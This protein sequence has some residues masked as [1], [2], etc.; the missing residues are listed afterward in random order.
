MLKR[1][2]QPP[3]AKQFRS[4][5]IRGYYM[6]KLEHLERL[7]QGVASWN[8]WRKDNPEITPDLSK[9]KLKNAD[10]R[11]V[12]LSSANLNTLD[13][14]RAD[15]IA[16]EDDFYSD[17]ENLDEVMIDDSELENIYPENQIFGITDL[18]GADLSGAD[19]SRATF[20][21]ARLIG[22]KLNNSFLN[23]TNFENADLSG[24]DFT[25]ADLY[26]VSFNDAILDNLKL[27]LVSLS[28]TTFGNNNLSNVIGLEE[29]FHHAPSVIGISTL[30]ISK[31]KIPVEFLRGCGLSDLEIE[32]AKLYNPDLTT[33][34]IKNIND[35]IH[36]LRAYGSIQINKLFISYTHCNTKFVDAIEKLLINEG[37][38]FWR[39]IHDAKVGRLERQIDAAINSQNVVLL[40]L[41]EHSTNSDWVEHEARKAREKEKKT[42]KDAMCP[43]ALDDSWKTCRWPARRSEER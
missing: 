43:I 2:F 18:S 31:G 36:D 19:L 38:R 5:T 15:L 17:S 3:F 34:E 7:M 29:I 13:F 22:V 35:L 14:N 41:S 28:R 32:F 10:L 9:A 39:D 24:A 16:A 23:G 6:A 8:K 30:Q 42:G 40:I 25:N 26:G 20:K 21:Y 11:N 33:E 37:I 27:N 4:N 1:I 12:D